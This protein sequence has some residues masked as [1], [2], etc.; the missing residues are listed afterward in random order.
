MHGV[1]F[2]CSD[3]PESFLEQHKAIFA[4]RRYQRGPGEPEYRFHHRDAQPC[5]PVWHDQQLV[6]VRWGATMM[7]SLVDS[8]LVRV[9]QQ[10]LAWTLNC[11]FTDWIFIRSPTAKGV[12]SRQQPIFRMAVLSRFGYHQSSVQPSM[13]TPES[14]R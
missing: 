1:A 14:P 6:M 3:F 10:H 8:P 13:T 2:P 4:R 11:R 9:Y 7:E 12:P 5:H